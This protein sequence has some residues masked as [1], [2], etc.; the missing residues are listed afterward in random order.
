MN[1]KSH[2]NLNQLKSRLDVLV[3]YLDEKGVIDKKELVDLLPTPPPPQSPQNS[4]R[5]QSK[6]QSGSKP[7]RRIASPK[8]QNGNASQR[9]TGTKNMHQTGTSEIFGH[10]SGSVY[11]RKTGHTI[12]GVNIMLKR[13]N[14]DGGSVT[15]RSTKTDMSGKFYFLNVPIMRSDRESASG[16]TNTDERIQYSIDL[17]YRQLTYPGVGSIDLSENKTT[18]QD[19]FIELPGE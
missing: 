2:V 14:N 18:I 19:M 7:V 6:Q 8:S 16:K 4:P 3:D 12:S 11:D 13:N 17:L 10:L 1:K 9:Q 15:A 5:K